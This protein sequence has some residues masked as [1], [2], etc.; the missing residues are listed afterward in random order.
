[1]KLQNYNSIIQSDLIHFDKNDIDLLRSLFQNWYTLRSNMQDLS[2][3]GIPMP[4]ELA[5]A[6]ISYFMNYS[7][8][9]SQ[10]SISTLDAFDV[11]RGKTIEIKYSLRKNSA[12]L[13]NISPRNDFDIL[14]YAEFII[15]S[16]DQCLIAI[17]EFDWKNT[18]STTMM[19]AQGRNYSRFNVYPLIRSN[20]FISNTTFSLF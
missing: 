10:S 3:K 9:R 6:I 5:E 13:F 11:K 17:Y 8:V 16:I 4:P 1:M 12:T 20:E 19:D 18:K 2:P 7:L 14:C 15:E